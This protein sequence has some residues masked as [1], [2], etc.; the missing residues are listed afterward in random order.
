MAKTAYKQLALTGK[1]QTADLAAG[2]FNAASKILVLDAGGKVLASQ[3]PTQM[4]EFAGVYN[5]TTNSPALANT[6]TGLQ[7]TVYR[8][9]TAGSQDF[10]AGSI[11]FQVGDWVTNN[12]TTW[13]RSD[14]VDN[15][16]SVHGRTGAVVSASGDYDAS[17]VDFTP[18][19]LGNWTGSADPGQTDD[20]LDQLALRVQTL[21]TDTGALVVKHMASEAVALGASFVDTLA[22]TPAVLSNVRLFV[23]GV[24]QRYGAAQDFTVAGN[25]VTWAATA[26][27]AIEASDEVEVHYEA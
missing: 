23:N 1:L 22:G 3:L 5:A 13:E 12:G 19:T 8:V 24:K 20:A 7:G 25:V 15:V 26:D 27:F 17:Q 21:E 10:G 18:A 11:T 16:T 4:M 6:D 2:E 9:G 14:N